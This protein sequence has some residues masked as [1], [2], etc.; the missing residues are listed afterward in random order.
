ME[1]AAAI[2]YILAD[3]TVIPSKLAAILSEKIAYLSR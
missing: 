1:A 2:D 3:K